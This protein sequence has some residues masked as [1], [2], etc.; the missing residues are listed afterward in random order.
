MSATKRFVIAYAKFNESGDAPQWMQDRLA[1]LATGQP[2]DELHDIVAYT[3]A[4]HNTVLLIDYL[5]CIT[6]DC[7]GKVNAAELAKLPPVERINAARAA[8][9][10]RAAPALEP[11]LATLIADAL[12]HN[13][14]KGTFTAIDSDY[15]RRLRD[16]TKAM[17]NKGDLHAET[18]AL[19]LGSELTKT[20]DAANAIAAHLLGLSGA[21]AF[22]YLLYPRANRNKKG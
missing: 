1:G 21:S 20:T 11:M 13:W 3:R 19:E 5:R 18:L 12:Q 17:L 4:H 16:N 2:P 6:R 14:K 8:G 7:C 9:I 10:T 15:L 22:K